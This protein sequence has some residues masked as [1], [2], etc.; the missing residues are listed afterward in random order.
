MVVRFEVG[1]GGTSSPRG[2]FVRSSLDGYT[3]DLVLVTFPDGQAAPSLESF[4]VNAAGQTAVTFRFYIFTPDYTENS[5]DF[6]NVRIS[7]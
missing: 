7:H 2:Y 6:R 3:S 4:I 5:I 1:K